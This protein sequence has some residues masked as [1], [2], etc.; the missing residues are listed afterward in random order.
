M[1]TCEIV[2]EGQTKKQMKSQDIH[3]MIQLFDLGASPELMAS[4][5]LDILTAV[6]QRMDEIEAGQ[7]RTAE[8]ASCLANGVTPD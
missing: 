2:A 8:V 6:N 1:K 3:D 5:V 4:R 7:R